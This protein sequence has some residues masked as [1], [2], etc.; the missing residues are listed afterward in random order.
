MRCEQL[1][2][3]PLNLWLV[4]PQCRSSRIFELIRWQELVPAEDAHAVLAVL[5][6]LLFSQ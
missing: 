3:E 4:V 1:Y 2:L 5:A 6:T